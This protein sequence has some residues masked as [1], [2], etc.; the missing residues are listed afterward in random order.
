[1]KIQSSDTQREELVPYGLCVWS[2]HITSR[3]NS[4]IC[5]DVIIPR[6]GYRTFLIRSNGNIFPKRKIWNLLNFSQLREKYPQS[7]TNRRAI[8]TDEK[9]SMMT[10]SFV[11]RTY[12]AK[13]KPVILFC[14]VYFFLSFLSSVTSE[15]R[16]KHFR[17]GWLRDHWAEPLTASIRGTLSRCWY[18]QRRMAFRTRKEE[19]DRPVFFFFLVSLF[20]TCVLG[21]S[22]NDA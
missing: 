20:R 16:G 21:T 8:L 22:E 15:R 6:Y 5:D 12:S 18:Q 1:M 13:G 19:E 9:V 7:Q 14:R 4:K 10:P 11:I 3:W 17:F 2:T